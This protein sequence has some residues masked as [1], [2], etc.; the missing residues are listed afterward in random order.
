MRTTAALTCSLMLLLAAAC[1]PALEKG[2][3]KSLPLASLTENRV[4]VELFLEIDQAGQ[5]WL[6]ARFTPENGYHLYSKDIPPSGVDGLG[7][8]TRLEIV[9]GSC[10]IASGD[11]TESVTAEELQGMPGLLVYPT[12]PVTLRLPVLLPAGSGWYSEEVSITYMAC[13]QNTCIPPVVG[14]LVQVRVPGSEKVL[15]P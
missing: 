7:R 3:G 12:G 1:S 14:K 13:R 11:L 8:P 9:P 10:M 2:A 4:T 6:A 15:E 5:A